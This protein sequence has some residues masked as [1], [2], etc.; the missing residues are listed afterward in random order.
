MVQVITG[1]RGSGKTRKFIDIVNN[2]VAKSK[3]EVVCVEKGERLR[4]EVKPQVRLINTLDFNLDNFDMFYGFIAGLI[5]S[6][7]D[8]TDI[9]IDGIFQI[10]GR[11][12]KKLGETLDKINKITETGKKA[13][14]EET[15]GELS[16]ITVFLTVSA[17]DK[18]LP[19]NVKKFKAL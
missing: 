1:A 11:D 17:D 16:S 19:E 14:D 9:Y 18:E 12:Y 4:F 10:A 15:Q 7:H 2:T 6:N 5:S 3:G 13:F 8:I